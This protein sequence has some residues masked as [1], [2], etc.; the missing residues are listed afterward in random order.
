MSELTRSEKLGIGLIGCGTIGSLLAH[1]VDSGTAGDIQLVA[2]YDLIP[3]R[4]DKLA[5]S[6][7]SKPKTARSLDELLAIPEIELVLEAGSQAALRGCAVKVLKAGKNLMAMSVGAFVDPQLLNQVQTTLEETGKRLWL[8][9]GAIA[10]LDGV[11]AAMMAKVDSVT[12]TTTKPPEG[13][14]GAPRTR[15]K[16]LKSI[17]TATEVYNGPADEACRLFPQNVNVAASLSLAGIGPKRTM[18]RIIADPNVDRNIHEIEVKGDFGV[19][20]TRV[21]NVPSPENPKTSYL[22]ILSALATLRKLTQ[23]IQV[24]T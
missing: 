8:P 10:G 24:G 3:E 1:K 13:L 23:K 9:S 20:K 4:A 21:E 18:V 2:V 22:A 16:D 5:E 11:K 15:D 17:E 6:L 7:R 12:L 19:L 14:A